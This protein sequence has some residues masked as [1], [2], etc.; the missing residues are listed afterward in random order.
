MLI[1]TD[2]VY[3]FT[4]EHEKRPECPVCGGEAVDMTIS[5][6][7]TVDKLIETL[8]ERQDMFVS[9][10]LFPKKF[11]TLGIQT[12]QKAVAVQW[13][14]AN[15]LPST[16]AARRSNQAQ[17]REEGIRASRRWRRSDRD[18]YNL[19]FQFVSSH[20]LLIDLSTLVLAANR[21]LYPIQCI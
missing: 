5:K 3:S 2:G 7:L 19:A 1:G 20:Q 18:S 9:P 16:A 15:L 14:E 17:P 13:H 10:F 12:D 4:F 8:I 21:R 6:E 11:L